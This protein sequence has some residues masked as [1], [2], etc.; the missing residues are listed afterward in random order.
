M[1][2]VIDISEIKKFL[3]DGM[4]IS[5]GGFFGCGNAHNIIDEILKTDV[6]NLTIVASDTVVDGK[7]I[8]KLVAD[9]RISKLMATHIGTNKDTQ[10]QVNEGLIELELIPQGTLAERLR[11]A[12]A[13]LG[14][15][16]T[17]TGLG[18]LV[19][20]GKEV[21]IVDEK[22]YILE[23]P[24]FVDLA[25]IKAHTA[26]RAGNLIYNG[27]SRNFNV[28]MAGAAKITIAE[29]ENIVENGELNPNF[30]HTPFVYVNYLVKA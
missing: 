18:T 12:S 5:I 29:V 25:I 17:R 7:G 26:D 11:S 21:I 24:I 23:K 14:G 13:G 30:I 22:E 1:E 10:K 2:K 16:L 3:K 27:S 19:Q 15:V 6:K 20:E 4:I 28:A 8:G 9:N